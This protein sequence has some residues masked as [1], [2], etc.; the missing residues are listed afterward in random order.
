MLGQLLPRLC[1]LYGFSIIIQGLKARSWETP[2]RIV[3]HPSDVVVKVHSPATLSCRAEGFPEPTIEWY[4]NG[5]PVE[6]DKQDG[7]SQ[8]VVLPE[9]SLFFL[10]LVPGRRGQSQ[11][12][13]YTCVA[14][15]SAGKA[16]S[17]NASLHIAGKTKARAVN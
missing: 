11:E 17:R 9:G 4:R 5:L 1:V 16:V 10:S 13:V 2:P 12:G 6:T 14:R 15:N 3:H 7:Q 8:P